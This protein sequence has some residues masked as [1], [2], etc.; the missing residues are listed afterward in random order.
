M[1]GHGIPW[2]EPLFEGMCYMHGMCFAMLTPMLYISVCRKICGVIRGKGLAHVR[3]VSSIALDYVYCT[4]SACGKVYGA[5]HK[6]HY[7]FSHFHGACWEEVRR[8]PHAS[9]WGSKWGDC[10]QM[11]PSNCVLNHMLIPW[12]SQVIYY[13]DYLQFANVCMFL[14]SFY[15][16]FCT[17]CAQLI[18]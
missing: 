16:H 4:Y 13:C 9:M 2:G 12:V 3:M 11:V 5:T 15:A 6:R 14:T 10:S 18:G 8:C 1:E 17:L 7:Q